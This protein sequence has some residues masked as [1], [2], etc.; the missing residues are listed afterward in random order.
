MIDV[1]DRCDECGAITNEWSCAELFHKLLALDHQRAQPWAAFHGV[2]VA[3]YML[4]H[5]S[6][7]NP[8]HQGAQLKLVSVF[9][10]AGLNGLRR[11]TDTARV[12]NSHRAPRPNADP[13][14]EP[15]DDPVPVAPRNPTF[16]TTIQD[17]AIDG[18]FPA[19]GFAQR[20]KKWAH[21]V[22]AAWTSAD[23]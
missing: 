3:C 19:D 7:L 8:H 20:V 4:Q 15:A 14:L 9:C 13:R 22:R 23:T 21:A 10:D 11:L 6:A 18:T 12:R 17:V 5:P 16:S 1:T 2:N